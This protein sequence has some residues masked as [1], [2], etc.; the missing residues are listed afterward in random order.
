MILHRLLL[1]DFRG[2]RREEVRFPDTG[3]IVVEGPNESGKTSLVDALH[4]LLEHKASSAKAAVRAAAPVGRDVPV[5]VEAEFTV[6]GTRMR[7][8]KEFVRGKRTVLE[9]PGSARAALTADDAHDEVRRLLDTEVDWPLWEALRVQQDAP[10]T[11]VDAAGDSDSLRRALDAAAGGADPTGDDSL[12][13]RVRQERERYLTASKGGPTGELAR[14]EA[15]VAEARAELADAL[16][17]VVGLDDAVAAFES[18]E[19][20]HAARVSA[21]GTAREELTR[22]ERAHEAA[23]GLRS[24]CREKDAAAERAGLALESA[25]RAERERGVLVAEAGAADARVEA[26][27]E[28]TPEINGRLSDATAGAAS[29]RDALLAAEESAAAARTA[30]DGAR[31]RGERA[32]RREELRTVADALA[33][34]ETVE[35]ELGRVEAERAEARIPEE[36]VGA[37]RAAEEDARAARARLAAGAPVL[38]IGGR[39]RARVGGEE[40]DAAAGWRAEVVEATTVAVG[41]VEVTVSPP[42]SSASA[43]EDV[44]RYGARVDALLAE[45]GVASTA[46]AEERLRRYRDRGIEAGSLRARRGDLLGRS[47]EAELRARHDELAAEIGVDP[48]SDEV[49]QGA[50][51]EPEEAETAVREAEAAVAVA[52]SAE[53]ESAEVLTG[54]RSDRAV[55]AA[56]LS[57]AREAAD[58]LAR[59]LGDARAETADEDLARTLAAAESA[60]ESAAEAA[61]GARRLLDEAL[62]DAPEGLL[63]NARASVVSLDAEE[64]RAADEVARTRGL[65]AHIGDRGLLDCSADAERAADS[66]ERENQALWRRARAADLLHRTLTERRAEALRG[67]QEPFHRAVVELGTLVYG[68]EFDVELA[69]DLTI[70]SR[71]LG[72]DTVPYASLSGGARE[73]LALIVRVAC[74]RIVG[75]DGVPVFLDD[76]LGFTDPT[77]RF[78]MGAVLAAAASST[79][80]VVLTCDRARF[81][82]VGGASTHVM[83]GAGSETG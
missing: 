60:A 68:R 40:I 19:A 82:G 59:R 4:M 56:R 6:A 73:Q 55:H 46:E 50:G 64:R 70:T 21:L 26:L 51:Q 75:T 34:L 54:C 49:E 25:R 31:R 5:V 80:V 37:I 71:R 18:A 58:A 44:V 38:E 52:R 15:R 11:Q 42:G 29:A 47:T 8:R 76:T 32:R 2:V 9:F 30:L 78:A 16:A 77:R 57:D 63:E 17:G 13:E 12:L 10:V 27:G 14:S 23:A 36:A 62:A 72:E 24:D 1:E 20:A 65:V 7:Y 81:A 67:Y 53:R 45:H 3:V 41:E 43:H 74:A 83:R 28:A 66:A 61:A 35:A 39:G 69:E 33:A 22:L 48:E 79:Q